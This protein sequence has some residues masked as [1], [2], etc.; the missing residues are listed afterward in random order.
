M[1][2]ILVYIVK[3][4][5][6]SLMENKKRLYKS[7]T[8]VKIAGVCAGIAEYFDIDPTLVRLGW[9]IFTLMGGA[10]IIGYIVAWI[11][12]PTRQ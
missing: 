12:M 5:G 3:I 1:N 6:D 7:V 2:V 4:G 9:V 11:V 10:G 8:D